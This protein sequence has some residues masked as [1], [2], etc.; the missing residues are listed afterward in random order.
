M[1]SGELARLA[2]VTVRALRHYHQLGVLPEPE[3]RS[4]G[5]RHYDVRD[6]IR[7]LRIKRLA[8]IG[9]PLEQMPGLLDD[10]SSDPEHL[11]D[12]LDAELAAQMDRLAEQRETIARLR[13]VGAAPDLPPELA[14]F[15]QLSA[16]AGI[17]PELV[18]FDRDQTVLLAHFAGAEGM[19]YVAGFYERLS[20][21]ELLPE[22][23][24][25]SERF[26]QLGPGSSERDI[27]KL[28]DG[29]VKVL[30]SAFAELTISDPPVDLSAASQFFADHTSELLNDQQLRALEAFERRISEVSGL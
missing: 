12:E 21:P 23:A 26:S 22:V 27:A 4:N 8:S 9:I 18:Q 19:P 25:L 2:G 30:E 10:A 28:V 6:L 7:V 11:L 20:D 17:S 16:A 29:F 13:V 1:R 14:P 24:R 15:L 5:Y 3:R